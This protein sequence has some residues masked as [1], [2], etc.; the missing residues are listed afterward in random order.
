MAK[1]L[2]LMLV[3]LSAVVPAMAQEGDFYA[4]LNPTTKTLTFKKCVAQTDDGNTYYEIN[5]SSGESRAWASDLN[6]TQVM[7]LEIEKVI[8]D[9]SFKQCEL[10]SCFQ[11]FY[12]L[13]KL[14]SIEGIEN[15]NTSKATNMMEMFRNCQNLESI[16]LSGFD[17]S[18][19]TDMSFMFYG[20]KALTSLDLKSF[21]TSK[22]TTIGSMFEWCANLKSI[23]LSSF[24]TSNVTD[25]KR[26]FSQ[27]DQLTSLDLSHFDTSKV[28]TMQK[29]FDS[30]VG[31]TSIDLS[32]F[33][34]S[35]V[36][37]M[38]FMFYQCTNLTSLDLSNFDTSK[39]TTMR[40]MFSGCENLTSLDLI[41]F[42]TP[43]VTD[44][45]YMFSNCPLLTSIYAS[46]SF[47]VPEGCSTEDM[48]KN[49]TKLPNFDAS[50]IDGTNTHY[51]EGGYF[52]TYAYK[53]GSTM[54]DAG[55]TKDVQLTDGDN[56]V[57]ATPFRADAISYSRTLSPN[58]WATLCLPYAVNVEDVH[59]CKIYSVVESSADDVLTVELMESGSVAAGQPVLI[60]NESD[61]EATATFSATDADVVKAPT[62]NAE[63]AYN[64]VG[65][66]VATQ[67]PNDCYTIAN[68]KF[69]LASSV[70]TA[71]KKVWIKGFRAYIQPKAQSAAA[72][73][74]LSIGEGSATAIDG[75]ED[76]VVDMLN[77]AANGQAEIYNAAGVRL[78]SLQK[79][80]NIIRM[81]KRSQKV[82]IK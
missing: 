11:L 24:D 25:M 34:T 80:F 70:N 56:F 12:I 78:G 14:K 59:D 72:P 61:A 38:N 60:R 1:R 39:V 62:A 66:F 45:D 74:L 69:W 65:S 35:N 81:G 42:D 18:S 32:N 48:F 23:D 57:A 46:A 21:D 51:G 73:V 28:T 27:C 6:Y 68:N 13:K 54:F 3:L 36:T 17:T 4:V 76:G 26:T 75:V 55:Q 67:V 9:E 7:N 37:L 10:T 47:K 58:R 31:L 43:I 20:C 77:A 16:D 2:V 64:L 71:Q 82:I 40:C 19:V 15:L 52:K 49:S 5:T 8:I 53:I 50:Q 41:N 30:S 33:D 63:N 79:G 22:V 29:M 44:M